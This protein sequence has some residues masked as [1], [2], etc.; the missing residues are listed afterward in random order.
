MRKLRDGTYEFSRKRQN[1]DLDTVRGEAFDR[2]LEIFY[3]R[4]CIN[5]PDDEL[6]DENGYEEEE[7]PYA[8]DRGNGFFSIS[9]QST[10][11]QKG[12]ASSSEKSA[13]KAPIMSL[14]MSEFEPIQ[15]KDD[16]RDSPVLPTGKEQDELSR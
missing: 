6:E 11:S 4:P 13:P 8:P 7:E 16:P 1:I 2:Y 3:K 14:S 12:E 15:L 9:R 10:R 5:L